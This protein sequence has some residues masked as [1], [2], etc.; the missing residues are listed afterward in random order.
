MENLLPAEVSTLRRCSTRRPWLIWCIPLT[1]ALIVLTILSVLDAAVV[2]TND[3]FMCY[4]VRLLHT[5]CLLFAGFTFPLFR[6][7]DVPLLLLMLFVV[8][9]VTM[10]VYLVGY[11]HFLLG[12]RIARVFAMFNLPLAAW[13]VCQSLTLQTV[14]PLHAFAWGVCTGAL[15]GIVIP[16]V[17]V[18]TVMT[19]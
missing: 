8:C 17:I 13:I 18:L 15:P 19:Y 9:S 6:W 14:G 5:A 1:M 10:L 16:E 3:F 11:A 2:L 4:D 12:I 7:P